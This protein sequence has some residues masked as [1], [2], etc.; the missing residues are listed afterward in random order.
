MLITLH[1]NG[2][3]VIET[4]QGDP[5]FTVVREDATSEE[6]TKV[7]LCRCGLSKDG[8]YCDGSHRPKPLI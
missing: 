5:A 4:T 8:Q 6:R 7:A 2:P 1:K 3:A